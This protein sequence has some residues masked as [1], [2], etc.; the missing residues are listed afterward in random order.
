MSQFIIIGII[1]NLS[2]DFRASIN[3]SQSTMPAKAVQDGQAT[4]TNFVDQW[5]AQTD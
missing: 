5:L 4:A 3:P 1:N 2:T